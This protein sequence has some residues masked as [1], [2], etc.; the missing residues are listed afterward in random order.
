MSKT[1]EFYKNKEKYG[2]FQESEGEPNKKK[3][4]SNNDINRKIKNNKKRMLFD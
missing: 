4:S 3:K 2:E 1:K